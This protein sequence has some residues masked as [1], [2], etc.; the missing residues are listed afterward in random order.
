MK[1]V[2]GSVTTYVGEEHPYL[3]GRKVK[4]LAVLRDVPGTDDH[5]SFTSDFEVE[6]AGGVQA[7]DRVDV[8]PLIGG[9]R[10]SFVTSDARAVDLECFAHLR[11]S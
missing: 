10:P 9:R 4:I 5:A 8:A 11:G 6:A 3:R 2:I 7:T 1:P